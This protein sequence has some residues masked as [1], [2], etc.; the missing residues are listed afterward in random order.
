MLWHKYNFNTRRFLIG[1]HKPSLGILIHLMFWCNLIFPASKLG[2][3][4]TRWSSP[5][6]QLLR[7]PDTHPTRHREGP[8]PTDTSYLSSQELRRRASHRLEA[9]TVLPP[10]LPAATMYQSRNS[11]SNFW[12]TSLGNLPFIRLNK[13]ELH[14]CKYHKYILLNQKAVFSVDTHICTASMMIC[15]WMKTSTV[16][17]PAQDTCD[18]THTAAL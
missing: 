6:R 10:S 4:L 1:T 2:W 8:S 9:P 17:I 7:I 14:L 12:T 13:S 15:I 16:F 11:E 5:W 3:S 18:V